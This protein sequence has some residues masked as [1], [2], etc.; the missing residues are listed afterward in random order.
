MDTDTHLETLACQSTTKAAAVGAASAESALSQGL[1][2]KPARLD[3]PC[4]RQKLTSRDGARDAREGRALP[5]RDGQA[6]HMGF[7]LH[8]KLVQLP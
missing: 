8:P 2:S 4:R 1:R 7:G 5:G 6:G 3:C